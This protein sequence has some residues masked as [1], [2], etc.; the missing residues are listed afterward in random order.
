M[1][2]DDGALLTFASIAVGDNYGQVLGVVSQAVQ[3]DSLQGDSKTQ[4]YLGKE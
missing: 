3:L 4:E 1:E 2:A